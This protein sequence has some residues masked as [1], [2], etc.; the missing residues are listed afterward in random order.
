MKKNDSY[1]DE[2]VVT[3]KSTILDSKNGI[4]ENNSESAGGDSSRNRTSLF[5]SLLI[6]PIFLLATI[7]NYVDSGFMGTLFDIYEIAFKV[8]LG[9]VMGYGI[10]EI[11]N[12]VHNRKENKREWNISFIPLITIFGLM[13]T[14]G[15]LNEFNWMIGLNNTYLL[16]LLLIIYLAITSSWRL[17]L[18]DVLITTLVS[19]LLYVYFT[20]LAIITLNYSWE[21]LIL[22]AGIVILSDTMAYIGGKKYGNKR[23]FKEVSPSKT[24]EGLYIGFISAVTFA[25][26]WFIIVFIGINSIS[27]A[28]LVGT[29]STGNS[30]YWLILIS[31]IVAAIAPFGDL[32]FSKIKRTYGKKDYSDI[33]PGHGGMLDRIDSHI[34]AFIT[35]QLLIQLLIVL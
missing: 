7:T 18:K 4:D 1:L 28:T 35:A 12:F 30:K 19:L 2:V 34:F 32:F 33:L 27:G 25:L 14:L 26:I 3:A 11:N 13:Y 21:T 15:I 31:I 5:I 29:I 17:N 9:I 8:L 6:I 22:L 16:M 20:D 24:R 10:Y 23:I